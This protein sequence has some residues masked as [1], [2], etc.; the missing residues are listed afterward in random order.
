MTNNSKSMNN[1]MKS[2]IENFYKQNPCVSQ[3]NKIQFTQNVFEVVHAHQIKEMHSTIAGVSDEYVLADHARYLQVPVDM[4]FEWTPEMRKDYV[5]GIRKLPVNDVFKQ[6]DVPWPKQQFRSLDTDIV[7]EVTVIPKKMQR[8]R[9][10]K[11]CI[12]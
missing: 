7:E 10:R 5:L 6:K 12:S 9:K 3:L 2:A 8:T 4:W 1:V 11:S